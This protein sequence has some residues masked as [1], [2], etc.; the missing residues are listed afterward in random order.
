M[1]VTGTATAYSVPAAE[2]RATTIMKLKQQADTDHDINE[3][4]AVV[5]V[6]IEPTV[7]DNGVRWRVRGSTSQH[8]QLKEAPLRTALAGRQFEDT[9]AVLAG[10]GLELKYYTIWPGWWPR[11]PFFDSRLQ[12]KVDDTPTTSASP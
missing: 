6:I 5:D 12:I 11:F 7:V 1:T 2:P 4:A 10:Q 3:S 9:E 8:P